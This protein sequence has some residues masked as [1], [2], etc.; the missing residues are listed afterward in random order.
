VAGI[1]DAVAERDETL[2]VN[3]SNAVNAVVVDR[4]GRGTIHQR[5]SSEIA[6]RFPA[7]VIEP[8]NRS[9]DALNADCTQPDREATPAEAPYRGD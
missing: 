3:L 1:G 7:T 5:R 8:A 4:Q 9:R 6:A 2:F